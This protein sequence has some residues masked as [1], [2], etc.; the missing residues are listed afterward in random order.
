VRQTIWSIDPT[1]PVSRVRGMRDVV[2]ESVAEP[3]FYMALLG[4]FGAVALLLAALGVYGVISYTVSQRTHEIGVR[5]ALGADR[6]DIVRLVLGQGVGVTGA[7]LGLGLVAAIFLSRL[8]SN[9][10]FGVSATDPLTFAL[11]ALS[12]GVVAIAAC[13]IPA[14]RATRVDPMTSL[15]TE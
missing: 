9:L 2:A 14:I 4:A 5:L 15:R 11:V 6:R 1:Q 7:G 8:L 3:R 13:Y 12:L 10:L